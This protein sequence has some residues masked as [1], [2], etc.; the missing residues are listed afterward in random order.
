MA[1][2]VILN[3]YATVTGGSTA[4]A[5]ASAIGLARRG[6]SVTLFTAVA[7]VAANLKDIPGLEVICLGQP[8]IVAD[9]HRWRAFVRGIY[10]RQ[11]VR[12][13]RRVLATLDPRETVVHVHTWTKALSPFLIEAAITCGF[14]VVLT[15]HDF[16]IA[17]PTGGFFVHRSLELC[18]RTPLS[19]DCLA[20]HCDRRSYAQKLWRAAR[21]AIQNRLLRIPDRI[22]RFVGVS[23]LSVKVMREFLPAKAEITM[24]RNPVDGEYRSPAPVEENDAFVYIGRF[25]AEKGVLL[26]AEAA[27]R[28]KLPA[29]FIGDGEVRAE[30]ERLCPHGIFTGWLSAAEVGQRV[31][32]ARALVFPPLWY[33]TL[34]LVVVEAAAQGVPAVIASK[35]AATDY[36][37]HGTTGLWFEHGSVDSLCQQLTAMQAPGVAGR[38]GRHAHDWY[39]SDP[40]TTDQHV[41]DLLEVYRDVLAAPAVRDLATA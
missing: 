6:V 39:W 4:V 5:H 32:Q 24:L 30:A 16:F 35:C 40:W 26:F 36:I 3:D 9:P 37:R 28:L 11:A 15:L 7:P 12:E 22:A 19:F 31:R 20:C 33:E 13:L 8:E 2:V 41:E 21:T 34:G 38:L 14:P 18:Q 29:I 25:S 27:G 17:C 1:R 10:N 23:H